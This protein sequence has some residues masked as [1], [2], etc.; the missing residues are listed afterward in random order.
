MTLEH[1]IPAS[2]GGSHDLDNLALACF[3]CN[4]YRSNALVEICPPWAVQSRV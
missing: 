3:Q 2:L 1:L 4:N